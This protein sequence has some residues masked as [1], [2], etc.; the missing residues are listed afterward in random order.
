MRDV[1]YQVFWSRSVLYG[2]CIDNAHEYIT[3]REE[4]KQRMA[5]RS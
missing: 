5:N 4:D 3:D 1:P 2:L